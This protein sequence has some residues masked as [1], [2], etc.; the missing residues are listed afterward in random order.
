M[1]QT[2]SRLPFSYHSDVVLN[3]TGETRHFIHYSFMYFNLLHPKIGMHIL[4]TVHYMFPIVLIW[5]IQGTIKSVGGGSF[6]FF[7]G[8]L[9]LNSAVKLLKDVRCQS[10]LQAKGLTLY[11]LTSVCIFSLLFS[12]YFLRKCHREL[13]QKSRASLVGDHFPY[14]HEL[15]V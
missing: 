3:Q 6:P 5:G 11:T 2:E 8:P 1:S 12:I 13:V 14:S 10:L 7:P 4:L 15:P 9:M